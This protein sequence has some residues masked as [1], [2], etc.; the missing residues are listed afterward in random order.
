MD[1]ILPEPKGCQPGDVLTFKVRT[2]PGEVKGIE[3]VKGK[4]IKALVLTMSKQKAA[5][6]AKAGGA[7]DYLKGKQTGKLAEAYG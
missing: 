4:M 7:L 5:P 3:G 6:A 2:L 1:I